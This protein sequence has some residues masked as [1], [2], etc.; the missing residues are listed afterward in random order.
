MRLRYLIAALAVSV[1]GAGVSWAEDMYPNGCV[2]CHTDGST[3]GAMLEAIGHKNVDKMV[4]T[5]P[6]DCMDCHSEDGGFGELYE[7]IHPA[8]YSDPANNA[9]V[10][11]HEGKCTHCH[12]MDVDT[13][14]VSLKSGPKN[15]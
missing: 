3:V 5:I 7:F 14:E 15:W 1:V 2:S 12:S 11:D 13:G 10:V 4:E 8:H 6:T 9:F